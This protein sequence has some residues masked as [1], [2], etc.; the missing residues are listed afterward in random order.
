[1]TDAEYSRTL[2]EFYIQGRLDALTKLKQVIEY[3]AGECD[4]PRDK[5]AFTL[6]NLLDTIADMQQISDRDQLHLEQ[7]VSGDRGKSV[8]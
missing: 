5:I 7:L 6:Q 8:H 4:K 3:A 1:M 2:A